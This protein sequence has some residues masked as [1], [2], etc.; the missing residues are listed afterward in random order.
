MQLTM[1]SDIALIEA[2]RERGDQKAF[3]ELVHRYRDRVFHLAVS[4]IGTGFTAEAEEVT[5]E[6]FIRVYHGLTTFRGESQ[7]SSWIYR[8]AFNLAVNL[9]KHMR[10]QVPHLK[11]EVLVSRASSEVDPLS[12]LESI[13]CDQ[14]LMAAIDELPEVYQSALRL[15]YWMEASIAEIADLLGMPENTV[16]SYLHR[17]R[18]L[19]RSMLEKGANA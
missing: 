10:Y 3:T 4:I 8:I 11:E 1:D 18:R 13:Q 16:K 2:Y 6:V 15:H 9:K 7:F 14:G 17:A 12:R 19:L 5:Q